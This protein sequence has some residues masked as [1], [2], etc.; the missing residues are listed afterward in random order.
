MNIMNAQ[1]DIRIDTEYDIIHSRIS[2]VILNMINV[3]RISGLILNMKNAQPD[4]RFDTEYDLDK[5][6]LDAM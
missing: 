6:R 2:G 5:V 4:I 3:S 1:P